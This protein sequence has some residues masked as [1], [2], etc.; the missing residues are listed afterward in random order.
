[1]NRNYT[2]D[3]RVL[4]LPALLCFAACSQEDSNTTSQTT[5]RLGAPATVS[6]EPVKSAAVT[7]AGPPNEMGRIPILEYH[8]IGGPAD[9]P[10]DRPLEKFKQDLEMLYA[11]GYRPVSVSQ[12]V[13]KK[14][15]LPAG[16][17][18]VV[19]TFDDASPSQFRYLEQ[20]GKLVIDPNSAVGVWLDFQK[21]HPDWKNHAVFCLLPAASD[22]HAFFGDRGID[23]QKSAWRLQ[24]V[25]WL[26]DNGFEL[27]DH[28]LWHANLAKYSDAVVREQ[29]ARG[30]LAID[31]AV[32]GYK[33]RTFALPLGVWPK[34]HMLAH[35]GSWTD[36]KSGKTTKYNFDAVLLVADSPIPSPYDPKFDPYALQRVIV[37]KEA[38]PNWLDRLEKTGS[39]YISDGNPNTIA[40][41]QAKVAAQQKS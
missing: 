1:M 22:G 24:K 39:R 32:P 23:G 14:I 16:Q 25:K 36:P 4:A 18:P 8:L 26:A 33:I 21:K 34:N 17:S 2:R 30:A 28:T 37:F 11:R 29:I 10:Y 41:P 38:L 27:C 20:N 7:S 31:S 15:D 6:A 35:T 5:A 19:F 12:V 13:D 3:A 40:K 9:G